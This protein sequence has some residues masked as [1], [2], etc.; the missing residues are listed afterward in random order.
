MLAPR[1]VQVQS[2]RTVFHWM[3]TSRNNICFPGFSTREKGCTLKGGCS[4]NVLVNTK[5][6]CSSWRGVP[7]QGA[8]GDCWFLAGLAVISERSDLI[9]RVLGGNSSASDEFGCYEVN[10]FKD[11]RWERYVFFISQVTQDIFDMFSQSWYAF[12]RDVSVN[13]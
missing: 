6:H 2:E 11:G 5:L 4:H 3:E 7:V 10:L 12:T 9:G 1:L 13:D 8:V